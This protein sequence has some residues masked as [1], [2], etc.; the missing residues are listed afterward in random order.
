MKSVFNSLFNLGIDKRNSDI[1]NRSIRL[2]NSINIVLTLLGLI[3]LLFLFIVNLIDH[4]IVA[5]SFKRAFYLILLTILNLYLSYKNLTCLSKLSTVFAPVIIF[6]LYP[7]FIGFVEEESFI[8]YAYILITF[9]IIPQLLI[10]YENEKIL[11]WISISIIFILTITIDILLE[12]FAPVKYPIIE[13]INTF[14]IFNKVAQ[15][16]IFILVFMSIHYLQAVNKRY[17]EEIQKTNINLKEK[18]LSLGEKNKVLQL[19]QFE[20][21]DKNEKLEFFRKELKQQNKELVQAL[22]DLKETQSKLV[23]SEKMASLGILTAGV[24]HEINNPLNYITGGLYMLET[25]LDEFCNTSVS[26]SN[27]VEDTDKRTDLYNCINMIRDGVDKVIKIVDQ[28]KI[29]SSVSPNKKVYR[30]I[31]IILKSAVKFI[32]NKLPEDVI[33]RYGYQLNEKVPVYP[34]RLQQVFLN[35]IDNALY[36]LNENNIPSKV[37]TIN[38]MKSEDY[39]QIS[40]IN[41]GPQIPPDV[42]SKIFDPFFTTKDPGVGTGLGLSISYNIVKEHKGDLEVIN[43]IDKVGFIVKIPLNNKQK[44]I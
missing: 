17:E 10:S 11:Y 43:E 20:L 36:V 12:H 6:I 19:K 5:I 41:N 31:H 14:Y 33:L 40:I 22:Q 44:I 28:L 26:D 4:S 3:L 7:T 37:I 21:E 25:E 34:D 35:I 24:A 9:S 1:E 15:V 18:S 8:Y 13:R 29:Y 39:A 38:T 30:D 23:Q 27:N 2:C 32:N 16:L 42:V